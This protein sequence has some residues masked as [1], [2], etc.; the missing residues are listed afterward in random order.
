MNWLVLS[1]CA[2][3]GLVVGSFL[4][5]VTY[6][7]PTGGSVISP[8]SACPLCGSEIRMR[9]RI[10]AANW[11]LLRAR[12]RD[13]GGPIPARYPVI[14]IGTG[15]FFVV[16]GMRFGL[17]WALPAFLYLAAISI[18]LAV[19]DLDVKRLPNVLVLPSYAV[20]GAL[21]LLPAVAEGM[22]S[23][24]LSAWLGAL[25][26]FAVYFGLAWIYPAGMGFGDVKLAWLLGL[27]LGWL[28]WG[29][30]VVGA[31]FG[32]LTGAVAGV[33]LMVFADA[34]RKTKIPFGPFML[35]GAWIAILWG[36]SIVDWYVGI[37]L[38]G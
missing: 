5:V 21:L 26:L 1:A 19:I 30:L 7:V 18:A 11:L 4:T 25:V 2:L 14:E 28:G 23:Q 29:V 22:W 12:C 3:L 36:Q 13:C 32:F 38:P 33:G 9:D 20:S 34:G 10:P 31:F 37:A 17:S 8:K 16:V 6:R 24:Y 27:Y 35:A 15:L